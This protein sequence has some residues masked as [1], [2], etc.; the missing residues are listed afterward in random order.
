MRPAF[1]SVS[2]QQD[3]TQAGVQER[4]NRD[5]MGGTSGRDTHGKKR[6]M[7]G[8]NSNRKKHRKE[9]GK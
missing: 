4:E 5:I 1:I 9:N 6:N 7:H 2:Q 8:N 3:P